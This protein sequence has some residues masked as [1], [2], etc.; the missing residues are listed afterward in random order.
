MACD[1]I[2]AAESTQFGLVEA[3][4]G[5]TPLL[6]GGLYDAATLERWNVVNRVL[7]DSEL[8][9]RSRLVAWWA[10]VGPTARR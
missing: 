8:A 3:V 7:L 1:M 6:G 10:R 9:D 5:L 2:W 4:I